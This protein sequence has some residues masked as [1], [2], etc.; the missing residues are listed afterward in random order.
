MLYEVIT[1]AAS[2]L[3]R[4]DYGVDKG[5]EKVRSAPFSRD[6]FWSPWGGYYRNNFV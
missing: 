2:L 4:F 6:P 3:V 1:E 5:R